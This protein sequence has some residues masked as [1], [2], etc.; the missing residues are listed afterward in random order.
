MGFFK[1][2]TAKN[3]GGKQADEIRKHISEDYP[4]NWLQM[5]AFLC[6]PSRQLLKEHIVREIEKTKPQRVLVVGGVDLFESLLA[7]QLSFFN[8]CINT[9]HD[10]GWLCEFCKYA[11]NSHAPTMVVSN[12]PRKYAPPTVRFVVGPGYVAKVGDVG[13]TAYTTVA[14]PDASVSLCAEGDTRTTM[15]IFFHGV[16]AM[17]YYHEVVQ[18]QHRRPD[19]LLICSVLTA[20]DDNNLL[21]RDQETLKTSRDRAEQRRI[22]IQASKSS[23][24]F[25][26]FYSNDDRYVESTAYS[27]GILSNFTVPAKIPSRL[28][29]ASRADASQV[30]PATSSYTYDNWRYCVNCQTSDLARQTSKQ[31]DRWREGLCPNCGGKLIDRKTYQMIAPY[32]KALEENPRDAVAWNDK[33]ATLGAM[34]RHQEAIACYDKALEEDLTNAVIWNN[35]G[36]ALVPLGRHQ[37]AILCCDRALKLNPTFAEAWYN[38]MIALGELGRHKEAVACLKKF[39]ELAPPEYASQVRQAED[40]IRKLQQ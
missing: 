26:R 35:K 19:Q 11:R 38:K 40:Y 14:P 20:P 34:G 10:L 16:H 29:T 7:N 24:V 39:I 27:G 30:P 9:I 25:A 6:F 18:S 3:R 28:A 36:G 12:F 21:I 32:D 13:G 37:E 22:M 8:I 33:G 4:D 5:F 1:K 15:G 31:L 2:L 23:E 17:S